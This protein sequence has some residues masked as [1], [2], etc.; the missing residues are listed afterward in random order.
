MAVSKRP[1]KLTSR[2]KVPNIPP[3]KVVRLSV[4][5]RPEI[6]R[7]A[8]NKPRNESE[9]S[10]LPKDNTPVLFLILLVSIFVIFIALAVFGAFYL[11]QRSANDKTS[12]SS[13]RNSSLS[14]TQNAARY[15][16]GLLNN[17]S[18]NTNQTNTGKN[19]A[20]TAITNTTEC[21]ARADCMPEDLCSCITAS[22]R[23]NKCGD[24]LQ[25]SEICDCEQGGFKRCIQTVCPTE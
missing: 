16:A 24:A 19:I 20:C 3:A 7:P 25:P 17:A 12:Q 22:T 18:T 23:A 21:S 6:I 4:V 5:E 9:I 15:R 13:L 8:Q 2:R 1:K 14:L 11:S 10:G